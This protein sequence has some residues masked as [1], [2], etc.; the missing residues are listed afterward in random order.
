SSLTALYFLSL[1]DALPIFDV[2]QRSIVT[3]LDHD[4]LAGMGVEQFT[5]TLVAR[6]CGNVLEEGSGPEHRVAAMFPRRGHA[7]GAA[8][9]GIRS[10]EHTSE[11]QS[12]GH[13]VCR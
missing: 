5:R 6:K 9:S 3:G 10:E 2:G 4:R 8:L 7:D 13:L 12:R 1:H 11:L